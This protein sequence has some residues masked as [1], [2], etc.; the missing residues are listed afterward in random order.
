M[1]QIPQSQWLRFFGENEFT[2]LTDFDIEARDIIF[3]P[4]QGFEV[5]V[6]L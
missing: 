3:I 5:S 1:R 4:F 2:N 6:N